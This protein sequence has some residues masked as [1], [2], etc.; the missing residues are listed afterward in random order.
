M[1]N[2]KAQHFRWIY[3]L[4]VLLSLGC[5]CSKQVSQTK[6]EKGLYAREN[7]LQQIQEHE[8][9]RNDPN[10]FILR[11]AS[12]A[13]LVVRKRAL[14]AIGRIGMSEGFS[15]LL[16]SLNDENPDVR[17]E[18]AFALRLLSIDT[19]V[20]QGGKELSETVQYSLVERL[21]KEKDSDV[22]ENLILTLGWVGDA[23]VADLLSPYINGSNA[24]SVV[25]A[26]GI[27]GYRK[28]IGEEKTYMLLPYLMGDDSQKH[29]LASW[30][31]TQFKGSDNPEVIKALKELGEKGNR[32][33]RIWA[34]RALGMRGAER[35]RLWL[36]SRMD[37]HDPGVL[38]EVVKAL[39]KGDIRSAI[40]LSVELKTLWESVS[41]SHYRL[42]GEELHPILVGL[43]ALWP[44][45]QVATIEEF[46]RDFWDLSN[47]AESTIKYSRLEA[48]SVDLVHCA[49]AQL[50]DLGLG[51]PEKTSACG[52]AKSSDI[53]IYVRCA[54][55]ARL[56]S[57]M[58]RDSKW[59]MILLRRY[60]EETL[61]QVRT[62]A[63]ESLS[64]VS[65]PLVQLPLRGAL[66]D[67]DMGVVG[68]GATVMIKQEANNIDQNLAA[69]ATKKL[70]NLDVVIF[71]K[72]ACGLI[73]A[74]EKV[75]FID[76]VTLFR[77]YQSSTSRAVRNC[78]ADAFFALTGESLPMEQSLPREL[79]DMDGLGHNSFP[80]KAVLVTH[81]GEIFLELFPKEAPVAVANF[82]RLANKQKFKGTRFHRVV[83]NFVVQGGDPRGDGWG[84]P[85]YTIPC[86]L[87]SRP[88]VRGSVGMVLAGRDTGGSQFF[89]TVIR[90]PQLD[91]RYTQFARV[92][93][94]ME[95]VDSLQ[96]GDEIKD[97]YVLK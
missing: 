54:Q 14:L 60:L 8:W 15:I 58:Q 17:K 56:I 40:N 43:Q 44:H 85:G 38:V 34:I 66:Q 47:A 1:R 74:L 48:H 4:I 39:G 13:D 53:P 6:Q 95:I 73:K 72:V 42:T 32:E 45:A 46:S 31:I 51:R 30:T 26:I 61:V 91:G 59:K 75:R 22:R 33:T 82:I 2:F 41:A 20:S 18:T 93:K 97:L 63:V 37:E 62:A 68:A 29:M 49:A 3:L 83:P 69:L 96:R 25:I 70:A 89:I 21:S 90:Q 94:G 55:V 7:L 80:Q 88:F 78:S 27:L 36:L 52:T 9:R 24:N 86:E 23:N 11:M 50:L 57:K 77:K 5:G 16:S 84:G 79:P 71:P 92:I 10:G 28:K 81:R 87:S 12:N 19:P 35:H 64:N 67:S 76:A 65:S